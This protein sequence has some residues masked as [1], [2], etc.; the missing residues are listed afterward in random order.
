MTDNSAVVYCTIYKGSRKQALYLY[1][2]RVDGLER[3]PEEVIGVMG[4]LSEVMTLK[5]SAERRLARAEAAQV[6]QEIRD[7][8]YYLQLPPGEIQELNP[9]V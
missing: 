6:L 1:T 5:L 8:G 3:V 2:D 4:E 9:V 7:K